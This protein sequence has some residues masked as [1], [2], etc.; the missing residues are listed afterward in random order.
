[1]NKFNYNK[2]L[3]LLILLLCSVNTISAQGETRANMGII[4]EPVAHHVFGDEQNGMMFVYMDKQQ[5]ELSSLKIAIYSDALKRDSLTTMNL[6]EYLPKGINTSPTVIA[7][8]CNININKVVRFFYKITG[9]TITQSTPYYE[10][11]SAFDYLSDLNITAQGGYGNPSWRK[12]KPFEGDMLNLGGQLYAK[13]IG[14]HA[15]G[16]VNL[17]NIS[18]TK[19]SRFKADVG[20]QYGKEFNIGFKLNLNAVQAAYTGAIDA[21]HTAHWDYDIIGITSLYIQ[22]LTENDGNGQDHASIGGARLYYK[23]RNK[24]IQSISWEKETN[25]NI[26]KPTSVPLTA[27]TSSGLKPFYR[28][29]AGKEYAT[30]TTDGQLNFAKAPSRADIVVEAYQPGNL[31]FSP[32]ESTTCTFHVV[33]S[34]TVAKNEL[35][36]LEGGTKLEELVIYSDAS[37]SGQVVVKSGVVNVKEIIYKRTFLPNQWQFISFPADIDLTE[38]SDL[39]TLGFRLNANSGKAYYLKSYDSKVRSEKPNEDAWVALS[40]PK[41]KKMKGYLMSINGS[42]SQEITFRFNNIGINSQDGTSSLFLNLD[43]LQSKPNSESYVYISPANIKGNTLRVTV[44]FDPTDTSVLPVNYEQALKNMRIINTIDCQG[45]RLS[46]PDQ[47]PAKVILMNKK[48]K[49][50]FKALKYISPAIIDVSDMKE[51]TYLLQIQYGNA[52]GEILYTKNEK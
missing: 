1:M 28:I 51:G 32:T 13:G 30:I 11:V 49:K 12:D 9:S 47:T 10:N 26:Y 46:L 17:E 8:P 22:V 42:E 39:S 2:V 35:L 50:I 4:C 45:I 16:W 6:M 34:I 14:I 29:T 24:Q 33:N 41:V 31:S 25:L 18:A 43:M 23:L 38:I 37:E 5:N 7:F 36:E 27:V 52:I 20:K 44:K 40:Q 3:S 15:A 48:G 21:N 19:Y